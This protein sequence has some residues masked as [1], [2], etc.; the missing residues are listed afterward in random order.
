MKMSRK[1]KI[2]AFFRSIHSR[3]I[4][5]SVCALI[6]VMLVNLYMF[7]RLNDTINDMNKVYETNV[8][9]GEIENEL[10]ELSGNV[11]IFLN[12]HS[13]E[14][15]M[16]YRDSYIK[17]SDTVSQIDSTISDNPAKAMEH[18]VKGLSMSYLATVQSAVQAK[19]NGTEGTM[20]Y[21]TEYAKT[22]DIYHYLIST[23]HSLNVLRFEANSLN[24]EVLYKSL[25]LLERFIICMLLCITG[26]LA[27]LLYWIMGSVTKPLLVLS[28]KARQV[29]NGSLDI[30]IPAPNYEDEVGTLTNAFR[31]MLDSIKLNIQRIKESSQ[32]EIEMREKELL[33]ENLLKDAQIKYYQAQINPHFLFNTLN[34]GQQ[35]AMMED[36]EKTYQFMKST[37]AF[38]RG[39]LRG[40]GAEST[41][42]EEIDLIDH[43][44]YIMNVRYSGEIQLNKKI[45]P[46]TLNLRFPGMVLQP[47][48]ENS[49]RY[50]FADPNYEKIIN[51][52]IEKTDSEC[53]I[54]IAD[55]GI[56]MSQGTL[57]RIRHGNLS[58]NKNDLGNGVGLLNVR[59][60]LR[61]R[62]G[63]DTVFAIA[64]SEAPGD[65]GTTVT[66]RIPLGE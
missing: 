59:E 53:V 22:Q 4:I 30:D 28:E 50:A 8:H 49:L 33:T 7:S 12:T 38:F 10:T 14:S 58:E 18:D 40:N 44:I 21:R 54:Q 5:P 26:Y 29:Q 24:Y 46:E 43:Y 32:R 66:I 9:L 37:A 64:S 47:I 42:K 65:H 35:L 56:G 48:V 57:E 62:Y 25:I 60:R 1:L 6:V 2:P 20:S 16:N 11:N 3:L 63:R 17:F 52:T 45:D 55:L 27:V 15:L 19:I 34:T 41:I 51:L 31:Q 39:Q 13:N 36:A 23:L 61:L